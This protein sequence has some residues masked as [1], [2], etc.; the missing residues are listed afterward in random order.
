MHSAAPSTPPRTGPVT[1][2]T[3][4]DLQ[5]VAEVADAV[6]RFGSRYLDRVYTPAEQDAWRT[7]G[8]ASLAA[9]WAAK[10]A[11]LKL[12]GRPDAVDPRSVEVVR[13]P[14]G[15]PGVVLSGAA[16][17]AARRAGL[18]PVDISLSHTTDLAMA[19][20]VAVSQPTRPSSETEEP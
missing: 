15:R 9:R 11:V 5:P 3:G 2:R 1:V 19:T 10:E 7:G 12:V 13:G 6:R 8:A 18:G 14:H 4:C 17:E 20:A 16:A